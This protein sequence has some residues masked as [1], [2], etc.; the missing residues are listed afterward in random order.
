MC[1]RQRFRYRAAPYGVTITHQLAHALAGGPAA[2]PQKNPRRRM[3]VGGFLLG[4]LERREVEKRIYVRKGGGSRLP[5]TFLL[6]EYKWVLN[7]Q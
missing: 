7:S 6:L 4:G 1:L 2:L 3:T 5:P